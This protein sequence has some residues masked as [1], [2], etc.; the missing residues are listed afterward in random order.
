M[1]NQAQQEVQVMEQYALMQSDENSKRSK[2]PCA[3]YDVGTLPAY[4]DPKC[5]KDKYRVQYSSDGDQRYYYAF[6]NVRMPRARFV[7][8]I[9]R[10]LEG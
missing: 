6:N 10:C 5:G 8:C 7:E 4:D 9:Q 3:G 2:R 1:T